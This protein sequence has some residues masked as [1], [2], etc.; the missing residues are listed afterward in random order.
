MKKF[1]PYLPAEVKQ[2]EISC[3]IRKCLLS[4]FRVFSG[5]SVESSNP[6]GA[7]WAT[8]H[9]KNFREKLS[10]LMSDLQSLAN[11]KEYDPSFVEEIFLNLQIVEKLESSWHLCE[12]YFLTRNHVSIELMKWLDVSF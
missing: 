4:S 10:I 2:N 5:F 12:S 6:S 7:D 1:Q 9:S 11:V 3:V 8:I